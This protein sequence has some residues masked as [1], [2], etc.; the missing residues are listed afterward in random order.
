MAEE[1]TAYNAGDAQQVAKAKSRQKTRELQ[2]KAALRKIMSDPEGRMWM[3]DLL[4]RCGVY[5]SSYSSDAL[6]MAFHEGHRNIGLHLTAEINRLS[7]ELYTRMVSENQ[8][9]E[10]D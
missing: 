2:K 4:S 5:H 9:K 7:P 8:E 3:W 1:Q 6:A 10:K